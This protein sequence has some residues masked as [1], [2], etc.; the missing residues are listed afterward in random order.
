MRGR[1]RACAWVIAGGISLLAG[2]GLGSVYAEAGARPPDKPLVCSS[3]A[4]TSSPE[5]CMLN[6]GSCSDGASREVRCVAEGDEY[7]CDCILGSASIS[8]FTS[9]D[10][11]RLGE[12]TPSINQALLTEATRSAC[13]WDLTP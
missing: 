6:W 10:F 5:Q 8:T 1:H 3:Y 13:G 2:G 4:A 11:C 12:S 9:K 7:R